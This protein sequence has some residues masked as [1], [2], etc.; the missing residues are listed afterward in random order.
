L[1]VYAG[2]ANDGVYQIIERLNQYP[3]RTFTNFPLN[4]SVAYTNSKKVVSEEAAIGDYAGSLKAIATAKVGDLIT[5]NIS[6]PNTYGGE[7]FTTPDKLERLLSAVDKVNLTQP[8]FIKM[9]INLSWPDFRALLKVAIKHQISGVTI[10][11]LNKV[12]ANL[13]DDL[14]DSVSGGLS[15]KPT[16]NL[17]NTLI[18]KTY[19]E[20]KDQLVII[21]VGGIFSAEDAYTKIKL[22]ATLVEMITGMVFEGPQLIGQVNA[23]LV[24]LLREDGYSHIAQA[25]GAS[26]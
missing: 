15:G 5:L 16:F 7:P 3:K 20:F 19:Q 2:L 8:V 18:S 24:K 11:N 25:I 26:H 6:C 1:V 12:R 10:G 23:G 4:I 14:P 17:S 21:G 9:P 13:Q 22:G